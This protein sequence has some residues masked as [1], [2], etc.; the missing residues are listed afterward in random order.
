MK[1]LTQKK[2]KKKKISISAKIKNQHCLKTTPK[3]EENFHNYNICTLNFAL[4]QKIQSKTNQNK[5]PVTRPGELKWFC[6]QVFIKKFTSNK[7]TKH[8]KK[9]YDFIVTLNVFFSIK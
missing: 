2:V 6:F 7:D 8:E 1:N 9:T 5:T 3:Q 4:K